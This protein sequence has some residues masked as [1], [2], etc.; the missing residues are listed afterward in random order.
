MAATG[1]VQAA[2]KASALG[3]INLNE[4]NKLYSPGWPRARGQ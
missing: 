1:H 3:A 4:L 2:S